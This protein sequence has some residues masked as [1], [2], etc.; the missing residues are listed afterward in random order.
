[1]SCREKKLYVAHIQ[2]SN[3]KK[4]K[5]SNLISM[6]AFVMVEVPEYQQSI[7]GIKVFVV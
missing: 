7:L 1:M 4:K 6:A 5:I 2:M 3:V